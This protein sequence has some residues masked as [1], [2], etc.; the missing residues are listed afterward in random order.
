MH[1]TNVFSRSYQNHN[2]SRPGPHVGDCGVHGCKL[3]FFVKTPDCKMGASIYTEKGS[4]DHKVAEA[5]QE[6]QRLQ[7]R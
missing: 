5:I 7:V 6:Y 1:Y 2:T 3:L 4:Q